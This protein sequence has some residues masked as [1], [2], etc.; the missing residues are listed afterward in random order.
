MLQCHGEEDPLVPLIFGSLT[1]EKLKMM[2]N[3]SNITF[4]TYPGMAHSA[5]PEVC[6]NQDILYLLFNYS[7]YIISV[8]K[9]NES[10]YY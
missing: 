10:P 5:C 3:P 8:P 7:E 6:I 9:S 1:V 2:L 4:K